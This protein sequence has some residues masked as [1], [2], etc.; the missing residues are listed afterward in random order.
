MRRKIDG[1]FFQRQ[2]LF[3]SEEVRVLRSHQKKTRLFWDCL[4][5]I[6]IFF[7]EKSSRGNCH[8]FFFG[9]QP[10]L[11]IKRAI[12][13]QLQNRILKMD[14]DFNLWTLFELQDE[15]FASPNDVLGS[16]NKRR[17]DEDTF[18]TDLVH[19]QVERCNHILFDVPD[20]NSDLTIGAGTFNRARYCSVIDN[21]DTIVLRS[22]ALKSKLLYEDAELRLN[23]FYMDFDLHKCFCANLLYNSTFTPMFEEETKY[24][25]K[26]EDKTRIQISKMFLA[27]ER[28]SI[29]RSMVI[30][31]DY[32]MVI[33]LP[34]DKKNEKRK[35]TLYSCAF[36]KP[37]HT[38]KY[39]LLD[40]INNTEDF[41]CCFIYPDGEGAVSLVCIRYCN[42]KNKSSRCDVPLPID[43]E[44]MQWSSDFQAF[45]FLLVEFMEFGRDK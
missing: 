19:K 23:E 8:D 20:H 30:K 13:K 15:G 22:E 39:E 33:Q 17:R 31:Y 36:Y 44:T 42:A 34:F 26:S 2:E 16:Q 12:T 27:E 43:V 11:W 29:I 40:N 35:G 28:I 7:L 14:N 10:A 37:E 41:Y 6:S 32:E 4:V 24:I 21:G 25:S 45:E 1:F 9:Q 18:F 5:K 3:F 38:E